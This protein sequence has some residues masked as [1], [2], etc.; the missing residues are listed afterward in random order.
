MERAIPVHMG[1]PLVGEKGDAFMVSLR[2]SLEPSKSGYLTVHGQSIRRTGYNELWS[3]LWA[4]QKTDH[5]S[6]T[7]HCGDK[8]KLEPGWVVVSGYEDHG[9]FEDIGRLMICLTA[10]DPVARWRALIGIREHVSGGSHRILLRT[11]D[12]CL[13]CAVDQALRRPGHWYLVL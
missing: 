12:C 5:C 2:M 3:A 7:P 11:V 8:I 10:C 13:Q 4:T 6:H 9:S 1:R